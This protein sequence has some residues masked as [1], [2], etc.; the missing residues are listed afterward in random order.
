MVSVDDRY[1]QLVSIIEHPSKRDTYVVR[2]D[3]SIMGIRLTQVNSQ[4]RAIGREDKSYDGGEMI[5]NM[6]T[7]GESSL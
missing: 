2:E 1:E 3:D 5:L 6:L 7:K 4:T